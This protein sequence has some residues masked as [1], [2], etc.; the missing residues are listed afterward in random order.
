MLNLKDWKQKT[1]NGT[2]AF[3]LI[4]RIFNFAQKLIQNIS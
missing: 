2:Y 4:S 1:K 3:H